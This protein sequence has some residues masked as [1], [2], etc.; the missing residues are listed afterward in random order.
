MNY[1]REKILREYIKKLKDIVSRL[2]EKKPKSKGNLT[3]REKYICLI[4]ECECE[5]E[6]V[7]NKLIARKEE[8]RKRFKKV[9]AEELLRKR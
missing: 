7:I 6:L 8:K 2:P 5:P 3:M 1:D 9:A 4:K